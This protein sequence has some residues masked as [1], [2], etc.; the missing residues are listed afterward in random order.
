MRF[1][2]FQAKNPSEKPENLFQLGI[3]VYEISIENF[4]INKWKYRR[5]GP[6]IQGLAI[7]YLDRENRRNLSSVV[8]TFNWVRKNI[9]WLFTKGFSS[10]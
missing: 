6:D 8:H 9:G 1:I 5:R 7:S 2:G 3:E 10:N 4:I